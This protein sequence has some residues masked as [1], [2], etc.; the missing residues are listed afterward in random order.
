MNPAKK[1]LGRGLSALFGDIEKKSDSGLVEINK[2]PI[3][4]LDRNK[5]QPRDKFDEEKLNELSKSIKEK[6]A[7]FC[8]VDT[9]SVITAMDVSSIYEVPLSL[10][11]E[12]LGEIILEKLNK[13]E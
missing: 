3:A 10:E 4:D 1:G 8:S 5:Y 7:L 2:V 6:I 13:I 11:K 12:G 9:N